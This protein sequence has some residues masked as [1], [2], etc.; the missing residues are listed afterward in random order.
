[1]GDRWAPLLAD[2]G[3]ARLESLYVGMQKIKR[4]PYRRLRRWR[5]WLCLGRTG[6]R[7]PSIR[8]VRN[9][10][11]HGTKFCVGAATSCQRLAPSNRSS[12]PFG[13]EA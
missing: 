10:F 7:F 8:P 13:T 4:A 2:Q 1:V 11:R 5:F 12:L 3:R 9:R 6:S